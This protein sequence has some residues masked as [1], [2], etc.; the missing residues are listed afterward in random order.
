MCVPMMFKQ[1][2][3]NW[4]RS[5]SKAAL[6]SVTR[7]QV[8]PAAD[9]VAEQAEPTAD[10]A[11]KQIKKG[12]QLVADNVSYQGLYIMAFPFSLHYKFSSVTEKAFVKPFRG[13]TARAFKVEGH[14]K[15]FA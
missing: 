9:K 8:K 3:H 2:F 1:D 4:L 12:A 14:R 10:K 7:D 13:K 5:R 15:A 6:Q 11:N